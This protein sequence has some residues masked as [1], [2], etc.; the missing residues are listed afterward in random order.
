M[1]NGAGVTRAEVMWRLAEAAAQRY[2]TR[3]TYEWRINIATWT[4][5]ATGAV[6]LMTRNADTSITS[7][8][9]IVGTIILGII[10][11]VYVFA[12]RLPLEVRNNYDRQVSAYWQHRAL[13][14][15]GVAKTDIA[16]WAVSDYAK[17]RKDRWAG[18][19][20]QYEFRR[21]CWCSTLRYL[22]RWSVF[23]QCA[24]TTILSLG[25]ALALW[26]AVGKVPLVMI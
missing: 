12:W 25:A 23:Y 22:L 5:L 24:T 19:D 2:F 13:A 10:V 15:A 4:A 17:D 7:T 21:M 16:A 14:E 11:L 3:Q 20:E 18:F 26:S 8:H 9:A 1:T 6:V